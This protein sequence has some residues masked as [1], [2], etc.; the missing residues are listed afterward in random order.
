[1]SM[2]F[3]YMN[4]RKELANIVNLSVQDDPNAVR[5]WE[6]HAKTGSFLTKKINSEE[7]LLRYLKLRLI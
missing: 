2:A 1:M 4:L 6:R 7:I 3:A 5:A